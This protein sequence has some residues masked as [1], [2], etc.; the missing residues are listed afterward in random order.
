MIKRTYFDGGDDYQCPEDQRQSAK[1][2]RALRDP[3]GQ[4][5]RSYSIGPLSETIHSTD[6]SND[7]SEEQK[8][9]RKLARHRAVL[10]LVSDRR[11]AAALRELIERTRDRLKQIKLRT[12]SQTEKLG[13]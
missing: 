12:N 2:R 9:R 4:S 3:T 1:R 11:A 6:C 5:R 7:M 10:R 13:E 8:L